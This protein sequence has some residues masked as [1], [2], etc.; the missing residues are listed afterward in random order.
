M[1][2]CIRKT[3]G[4]I[5]YILTPELSAEPDPHWRV[6][7]NRTLAP[8]E[9]RGYVKSVVWILVAMMLALALGQLN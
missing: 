8:R 6:P 3:I 5:G 9:L 1:A 7:A 2:H 4:M